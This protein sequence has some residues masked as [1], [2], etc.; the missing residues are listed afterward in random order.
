M[1]I[2]L[3]FLL[4]AT[5][6]FAVFLTYKNQ[7]HK[8]IVNQLKQTPQYTGLERKADSIDQQT[9]S[10]SEVVVDFKGVNAAIIGIKTT[11]TA[12][13]KQL[14]YQYDIVNYYIAIYDNDSITDIKPMR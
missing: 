7:Q 1:S 2:L 6:V 11:K 8:V 14:S 13:G 4:T 3:V 5:A 12:V 9:D 10:K